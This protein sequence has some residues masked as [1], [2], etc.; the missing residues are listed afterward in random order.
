MLPRWPKGSPCASS[1]WLRRGSG[2]IGGDAY[3]SVLEAAVVARVAI[4]YDET[5]ADLVH[6]EEFEAVLFPLPDPVDVSSLVRVDYDDRDL[7]T[8]VPTALTYR[9]T[10]ARIHTKSFFNEHRTGPPRPP[11]AQSVD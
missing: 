11:H 10:E 6:D 3:G 9:L 8:D 2:D 5:K 1:T 7:R 4:R